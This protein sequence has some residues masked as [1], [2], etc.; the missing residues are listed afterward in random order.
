MYASLGHTAWLNSPAAW[1]QAILGLRADSATDARF[2]RYCLI[3]LR[4]QLLEQVRSNTQAN[5]NAEVVGNLKL[6]CPSLDEQRGIADFLDAETARIDGLA[7]A[8]R[9]MRDLLIFRRE[10][11]VEQILG[12]D[13]HPPMIPLKYAVRSVSVGIVIT[14]ANWYVEDGGVPALRG[15][16]I[17]PGRIDGSN[18]VQISYEGHRD[19]IK[20]RL[21]AGDVVVVRTGQAGAAAVVPAELDGS[22]CI[23]LLIIRPGKRTDQTFLTHY[24]NSFYARDKITEHSVGSIQAHFNVASMKNLDFPDIELAEQRRRAARLD[25][26]V[27][28][29]DLLASQLATQLS[30][31]AERRQA[32]ITAAVTGQIGVLQ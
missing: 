18:M 17:Q 6:P 27:G 31:L 5:L 32:L 16:N 30:L 12:L 13:A 23:D 9:K 22:N 28:E 8:R 1:N 24:L 2:L 19:N 3:S 7:A 20:S 21:S 4:P 10:R 15:L 29:L 14:P 11:T 26:V 25:E